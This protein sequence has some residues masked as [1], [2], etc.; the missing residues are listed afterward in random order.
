M[1]G[2]LAG[3]ATEPGQ[4]ELAIR[5]CPVRS[6]CLA[7]SLRHW[8]IGQYGVWGGLVAAERAG[9]RSR[10]LAR[11]GGTLRSHRYHRP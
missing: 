10:M 1:T 11:T 7:L 8:D 3:D 5:A 4:N 6:Q 9:L 2:S